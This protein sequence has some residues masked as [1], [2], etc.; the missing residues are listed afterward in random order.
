MFRQLLTVLV[1]AMVPLVAAQEKPGEEKIKPDPLHPRV[2][3]E[4]SSGDIILE[5]DG[6]KAPITVDSFLHYADDGFYNGTIFHRVVRKGAPRSGID[7]IQGGG[8]TADMERKTDG[9][10]KP[11]KN[12]WK[13]GLKNDRGTISMARSRA[14]DSA[15]SQFFINTADNQNL[16]MPLGGAAYAVFGKVVEG[17]DVVDKIRDTEL[18]THPKVAQMGK[19]VPA[20]PIVIKSVTLLDELTYAKV[21]EA[22]KPALQA[23]AEA[24]AKEAAERA[25]AEAA[26]KAEAQTRA[27]TFKALLQN[28]VD[29]NGNKLHKSPTGLMYVILKAGD[30]PSPAFTDEKLRETTT[31]DWLLQNKDAKRLPA[32]D[33]VEVHYT[34]WLLDGTQFDSSRDRGKPATFP[35]NNVVKGW[36]EGV[37]MM[38]VGG[39]R[40]LILPPDLAYGPAGRPRIPA[41]ST[42]V[43][44]VEL[45]TI[46]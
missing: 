40:L 45:L 38:K 36:F 28:E 46:K 1:I 5:L 39:R 30:G 22:L 9:L 2:K 27:Q 23:A 11:I 25:K 26:R 44:D 29:E 42:L 4:T 21:G 8:H 15:T 14:P 31:T 18:T 12:E 35:L 6:Q 43:F 17:L 19:V 3:M 24:A 10:R 7:V 37:S 32:M 20:E 41:N 13:N 33:Q 34:G 16:N